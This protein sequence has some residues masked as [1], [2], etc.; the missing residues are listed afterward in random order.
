MPRMGLISSAGFSGFLRSTFGL[1][2]GFAFGTGRFAAFGKNSVG[3]SNRVPYSR[4]H[5]SSSTDA[6]SAAMVVAI[7]SYDDEDEKV[8][9]SFNTEDLKEELRKAAKMVKDEVR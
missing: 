3:S 9:V 1:A 4:L 7:S 2:A 6:R 8:N 5:H